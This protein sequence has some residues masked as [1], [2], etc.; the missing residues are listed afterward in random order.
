MT[1]TRNL[2]II[3]NKENKETQPIF[4]GSYPGDA[5]HDLVKIW[6]VKW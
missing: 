5:W 1:I 3:N 6:N 4:E 2:F